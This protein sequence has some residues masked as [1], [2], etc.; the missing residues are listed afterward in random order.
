MTPCAQTLHAVTRDRD[1]SRHKLPPVSPSQDSFV[2]SLLDRVVL[3]TLPSHAARA[4]RRTVSHAASFGVKS[5]LHKTGLDLGCIAER[6][7][8]KAQDLR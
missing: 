3:H 4:N 7:E 2:A 8:A 5:L 6:G 1:A